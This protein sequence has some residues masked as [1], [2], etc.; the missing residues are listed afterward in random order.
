MGRLFS[1]VT[2]YPLLLRH[3]VVAGSTLSWTLALLIVFLSVAVCRT[4]V[5]SFGETV[6]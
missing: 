3:A 2:D 1:V 4:D 5:I 6:G